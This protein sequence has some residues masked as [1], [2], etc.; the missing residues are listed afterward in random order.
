MNGFAE[1]LL[2]GN[3]IGQTY[4]LDIPAYCFMSQTVVQQAHGAVQIL[5]GAGD[6]LLSDHLVSL[7]CQLKVVPQF[8]LLC[9]TSNV[10]IGLRK[11]VR[12]GGHVDFL[13][14]QDSGTL[15]QDF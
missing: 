13:T 12:P 9:I 15:L 1:M 2:L 7:D 8:D 5:H 11:G 14:L 10:V 3:F 4:V 6:G